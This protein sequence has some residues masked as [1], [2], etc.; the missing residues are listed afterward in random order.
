MVGQI[1]EWMR[2]AL[3]GVAVFIVGLW[4]HVSKKHKDSLEAV[5]KRIDENE[6]SSD[7]AHRR[8]DGIDTKLAVLE[9]HVEN[10]SNERREIKHAIEILDGKIDTLINRV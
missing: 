1:D 4:R 6:K 5:H 8:I 2:W 10:G 3:G 7:S 9:T